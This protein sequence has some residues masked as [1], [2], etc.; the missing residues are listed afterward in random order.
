MNAL[1]ALARAVDRISDEAGRF[2]AVCVIAAT[3]VC[4]GNALMRYGLNLG[5]NA[6]IEA[7]VML[8]GAMMYFGGAQTLRL[9]E[10]IRIDIVYGALSERAR[11]WIDTLGFLFAL[12]PVCVLM[13]WLSW[14]LFATSWV[15]QEVSANAGGLPVWPSKVSIPIGFALLTLQAVSELIKR[16]AALQGRMQLDL[17]YEKPQQ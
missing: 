9:N 6:W 4:V 1:L 10:H 3:V 8:F 12:L 2:A 5:S 14:K 17:A 11:L 13:T 7:Q 16:V 15:S